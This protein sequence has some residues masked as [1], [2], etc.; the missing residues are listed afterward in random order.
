MPNLSCYRV[1]EQFQKQSNQCKKLPHR[2]EGAAYSSSSTKSK[3]SFGV[4]FNAL[5][6][7]SKVTVDIALPFLIRESVPLLILCLFIKAYVD[8][9]FSF[10]V[11]Q[12]G[13]YKIITPPLA[14]MIKQCQYIAYTQYKANVRKLPI[15]CISSIEQNYGGGYHEKQ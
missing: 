14:K 12:R 3:I 4:H 6:R 7:A 9:P 5:Q 1:V 10:I 8:T 13:L 2:Y 15:L 11:F